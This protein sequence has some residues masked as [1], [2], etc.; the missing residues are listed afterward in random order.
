MGLSM[1]FTHIS[2]SA[3]IDPEH[4][5]DNGLSSGAP[6]NLSGDHIRGI[7][8]AASGSDANNELEPSC[9]RQRAARHWPAEGLWH[10]A[11]VQTRRHILTCPPA[12]STAPR[13]P[14]QTS[15][16]GHTSIANVSS[17]Y[18]LWHFMLLS[19]HIQ[20]VYLNTRALFH[21][22]TIGVPCGYYILNCQTR[23]VEHG[24][25]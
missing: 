20:R 19:P 25:L 10:P 24:N 8:E 2:G 22:D 21:R 16:S 1:Y 18:P 3:T 5:L 13:S 11:S 12:I 7:G 17:C 23:P 6:P 15:G 9:G 14:T 4:T